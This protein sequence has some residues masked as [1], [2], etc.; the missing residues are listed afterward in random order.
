MTRKAHRQ[1]FGPAVIFEEDGSI[2]VSC[3]WCVFRIHDHCTH[4]RPARKIEDPNSTPEWC[5]MREDMLRDATE[6]HKSPA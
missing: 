2:R 3:D 1:S 6:R 4:V 5:A